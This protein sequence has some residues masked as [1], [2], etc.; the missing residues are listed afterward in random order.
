MGREFA[1]YVV[2]LTVVVVTCLSSRGAS[3]VLPD[4]VM[5]RHQRHNGERQQPERQA[6]G[7]EMMMESGGGLQQLR[8][9]VE[10]EFAVMRRGRPVH[11]NC[12]ATS[13]TVSQPPYISFFVSQ[14]VTCIQLGSRR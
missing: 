6:G 9:S 8:V 3:Y 13:D 14:S 12:T 1:C 5:P 4:D 10:P 11:V 2:T 7:D